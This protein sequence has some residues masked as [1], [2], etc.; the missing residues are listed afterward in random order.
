MDL[1]EHAQ[2][3]ES[4][5]G[6]ELGN[7]DLFLAT[8]CCCH[9]SWKMSGR[10]KGWLYHLT[11]PFNFPFMYPQQDEAFPALPQAMPPGQT[12]PLTFCSSKTRRK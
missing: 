7:P 9:T 10:P 3:K 8:L 12:S 4:P 1:V 5:P 2:E 6:P 11:V